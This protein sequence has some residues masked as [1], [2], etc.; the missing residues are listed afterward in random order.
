MSD[1]FDIFKKLNENKAVAAPSPVQWIVAGL[2]NPDR[3]YLQ[4]RHN[5][6]FTTIDYFET[7]YHF[8]CDRQKFRAL[9]GEATV[10]GQRVLFMKPL[11]YMN[12]SGVAIREA[13]DFY[14]IPPERILVIFDDISLDPGKMRIRRKGSAG[15]HNGI[16][17]II[18]HLRSEDF[19]RIKLGIGDRPCKEYDLKDWVLGKFNE[20]D[21]KAVTAAVKNAAEAMELI[22]GGDFEKAMNSYN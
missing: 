9:T 4:T 18:Y 19:P 20:E 1:I 14:K 11:T 22:L 13:A 5:V 8:R 6:G 15:G 10:A 16:K 7:Q 12:D 17:S 3:E 21:G 2:G